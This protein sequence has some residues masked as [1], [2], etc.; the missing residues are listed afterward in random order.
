[1]AGSV[2]EIAR[3]CHEA[4]RAWCQYQ[5][6]TSQLP[7]DKAPQWQRD[8]AVA[9]V[10]FLRANPDAGD[11]ATHNSW[12]AQ[13]LADGWAYGKVKDPE[14]KTHPCLVPFCDLPPEQQFKDKLFRTIVLA[15]I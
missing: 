2:E 5:G 1:M 9:G 15:S 10:T 4:N 14:A 7:W 13:K 12:S 11:D 3:I 8:S 6:D